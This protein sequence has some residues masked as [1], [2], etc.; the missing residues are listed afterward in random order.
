MGD[1]ECTPLLIA[2]RQGD[3]RAYSEFA[4]N[5]RIDAGV[6]FR[7]I[8]AQDATGA[9]AFSRDSGVGVETRS[10]RGGVGAATGTA[11]DSIVLRAE[12]RKRCTGAA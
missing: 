10:Q 3:N 9:Q 8:A 5:Q 1:S 6:G 7:I 11:D 4:A 12:Q 2:Q